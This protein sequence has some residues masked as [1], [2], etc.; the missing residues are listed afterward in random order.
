MQHELAVAYA[1]IGDVQGRPMFPNLG[2]TTEALKS[3]DKAMGLLDEP[4]VPSPNP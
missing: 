2:Q 1:K 3:Y 4:L